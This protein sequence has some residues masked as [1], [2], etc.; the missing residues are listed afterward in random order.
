MTS[1]FQFHAAIQRYSYFFFMVCGSFTLCDPPIFQS[2]VGRS[3]EGDIVSSFLCAEVA[4]VGQVKGRRRSSLVDLSLRYSF[5][6]GRFKDRD[7]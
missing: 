2:L 1:A 3:K 6:C 4:V 5:F 7:T